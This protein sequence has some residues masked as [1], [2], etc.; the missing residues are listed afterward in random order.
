MDAATCLA[1]L[2]ALPG[3]R[4]QGHTSRRAESRLITS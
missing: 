3:N 4:L 2:G 1:D